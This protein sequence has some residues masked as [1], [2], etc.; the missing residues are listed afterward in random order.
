MDIVIKEKII[1][2]ALGYIAFWVFVYLC[3]AFV[4]A[5]IDF[6]T[7]GKKGRFYYALISSWLSAT[8]ELL[9]LMKK[10]YDF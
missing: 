4:Y 5:D 1:K 7:W 2:N 9:R 8:N 6:D 3:F 10:D